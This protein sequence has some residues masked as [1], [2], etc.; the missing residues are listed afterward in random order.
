MLLDILRVFA[1]ALQTPVIVLLIALVCAIVVIV[2]MLVAEVFT[3][4]L[5]FKVSMPR[6]VDDLRHDRDTVDVIERSEL[7]RR[8]KDALIE[9]LSHPD[10]DEASRESLAVNL[11]AQEQARFD[12]RVKVTDT[13]AKVAPML[14]LM[15]TLIPLGPGL[16]AIGEGDTA[17]LSQ[18]LL[19]AFDTTILGLIVAAV[20]LVVSVIRKTWYAKYMAAFESAAECTL[21]IANEKAVDAGGSVS[22]REQLIW[23]ALQQQERAQ[24]QTPSLAY[25]QVGQQPQVMQQAQPQAMQPQVAQQAQPQAQAEQPQFRFWQRAWST[26]Q[27]QVQSQPPVQSHSNPQPQSQASSLAGD[28]LE[29]KRGLKPRAQ[30]QPTPQAQVHAQ[31]RPQAQVATQAQ[32]ALQV[33]SEPQKQVQQASQVQL[34]ARST[35]ELQSQSAQQA[36]SQST[37]QAQPQAQAQPTPQ[38]QPTPQ[39]QPKAA[40]QEQAVDHD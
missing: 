17:L 16:I 31:L 35:S 13:I 10:I 34:Q 14:G 39:P 15:G 29:I 7:L 4:R 9:L 24:S 6:L 26:T 12:I 18:S 22:N 27:P 36:Q 21:Q 30:A 19:I 8:Q 3:E 33:Q 5:E 32:P 23:S 11:V 28:S 20:A 25:A 38:S 37:Q 2:G 1:S 40:Q